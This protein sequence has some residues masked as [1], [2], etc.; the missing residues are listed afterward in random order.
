MPPLLVSVTPALLLG[1][2]LE[3]AADAAAAAV[4]LPFL[5]LSSTPAVLSPFF[6][7]LLA[8]FRLLP[9]L[10]RTF[11]PLLSSSD[12]AFLF[13]LRWR[14]SRRSVPACVPLIEAARPVPSVL[15]VL[16]RLAVPNSVTFDAAAGV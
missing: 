13:P 2:G 3:F 15:V 5:F 10:P 4:A 6:P 1:H 12:P 7:L 9:L 8:L 16:A 11:A 14:P